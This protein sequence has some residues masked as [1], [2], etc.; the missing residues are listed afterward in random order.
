MV[1]ISL[2]Q[3]LS[4]PK[5]SRT[6]LLVPTIPCFLCLPLSSHG[7]CPVLMSTRSQYISSFIS[8]ICVCATYVWVPQK[9]VR[10]LKLKL[11]AVRTVRNSGE[12]RDK[13]ETDSNRGGEQ[14]VGKGSLMC[15]PH[16]SPLSQQGSPISIGSP[17]PTPQWSC[18]ELGSLGVLIPSI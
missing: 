10:S 9:T 5:A 1:W 16:P 17:L 8:Y 14:Y 11:Q 7:Y 13:K 3:N 6:P 15:G 18:W 2:S 4:A 12:G